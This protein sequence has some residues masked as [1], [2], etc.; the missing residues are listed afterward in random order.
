[1]S[2]RRGTVYRKM[3]ENESLGSKHK[4]KNIKNLHIQEDCSICKELLDLKTPETTL[5]NCNH[6]FHTSCINPWIN[7]IN[8]N[9]NTCPLC[10]TSINPNQLPQQQQQPQQQQFQYHHQPQIPEHERR[11]QQVT[12]LERQRNTPVPFLGVVVCYN[13][14]IITPFLIQNAH[15]VGSYE[16]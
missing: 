7:S 3:N 15:F 8:P 12:A 5:T 11:L 1:M 14:R 16:W 10:R 9:A 6:I 4:Y 13:D 2:T